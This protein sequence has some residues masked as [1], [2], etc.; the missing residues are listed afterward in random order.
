MDGGGTRDITGFDVGMRILLPYLLNRGVRRIDYVIISHF[1]ADHTNGLIPV[2]ENLEVGNVVISRQSTVTYN[3]QRIMGILYENQIPIL[4]VE[5]GHRIVL[6]H[7]T[8]ID[9]LHPSAELISD[10]RGGINNNSIICRLVYG[11]FSMIF[12]GDVE[13]IGERAVV[14][15]YECLQTTVL[16]VAHHGS[17]TSSTQEFIDIVRPK[18]SLIGVGERNTFGHPVPEVLDRLEQAR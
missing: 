15:R 4:I 17:R 1:H 18:I 2:F 6:D 3:Y 5:E 16:K 7:Y 11:N 12:A 9:I 8:H 10:N 14:A 13:Q